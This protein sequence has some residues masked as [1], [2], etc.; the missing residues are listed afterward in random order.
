M[1]RQTATLRIQL[2]SQG[3]VVFLYKVPEQ[4]VLWAMAF[5]GDATKE[6]RCFTIN[7]MY[8]IRDFN[9]QSKK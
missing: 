2:L 7:E 5:I 6:S 1:R 8:K 9:E 3:R 4:S